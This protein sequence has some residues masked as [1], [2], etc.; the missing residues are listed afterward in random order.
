MSDPSRVRLTRPSSGL[1]GET[2]HGS[3][4]RQ[5]FACR[6]CYAVAILCFLV[7][8]I[9]LFD[10]LLDLLTGPP[11]APPPGRDAP[12]LTQESPVARPLAHPTPVKAPP[13][14]GLMAYGAVLLGLGGALLTAARMLARQ[15]AS[16]RRRHRHRQHHDHR[17]GAGNGHA[18]VSAAPDPGPSH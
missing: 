7:G 4:R 11:K 6:A 15:R 10:G 13:G 2:S 16:A 5:G 9:L 12:T 18:C 1:S 8:G 3:R 17:S 14:E